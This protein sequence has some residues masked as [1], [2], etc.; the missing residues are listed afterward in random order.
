MK[1]LDPVREAKQINRADGCRR[2]IEAPRGHAKST[3]FTFK[4]DLHAALYAY[5][6][7]IIILSDSSEQAEGFLADIKTELEENAALKEDFGA[8]EGKVWKASVI[9][10][11]RR[12]GERRECQHPG[13]AEEAAGLVL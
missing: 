12:P 13:A 8:L 9:H 7:C 1:G 10:R 6:H 2:A 4:D 5:K 11:L 3:N